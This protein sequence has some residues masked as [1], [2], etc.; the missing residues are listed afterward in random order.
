MWRLDR[1]CPVGYPNWPLNT[2]TPGT[3]CTGKCPDGD[4]C[5]CV[6]TI[7]DKWAT[8]PMRLIYAGGH[9]HAP[10]C[11]SI[12][13]YRNDTGE[14]LCRQLPVYGTGTTDKWDQAGYLTL[15]PCLW[16][17]DAGLEPSVRHLFRPLSA[18]QLHTVAHVR[19]QPSCR[20]LQVLL[21]AGVPLLSIKK[22]RNTY[23]GHYGEMASWQMRGVDS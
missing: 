16:G 15:P 17:D 18:Q 20:W 4:D 10:S 7:H 22:N 11:V 3:T 9:C 12:E 8:G 13:L 5:E 23:V 19:I 1:A 21:P 6:H 2:P 14:L